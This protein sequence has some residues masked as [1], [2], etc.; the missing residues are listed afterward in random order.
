MMRPNFSATCESCAIPPHQHGEICAPT[1][2]FTEGVRKIIARG[3][4]SRTPAKYTAEAVI[5]FM[6]GG[7]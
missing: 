2:V 5:E 1:D 6:E 7:K 4:A 3:M